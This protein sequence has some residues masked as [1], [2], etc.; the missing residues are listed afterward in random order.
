MDYCNIEKIINVNNN[1]DWLNP[2]NPIDIVNDYLSKGWILLSIDCNSNADNTSHIRQY[3][4]G[5][6][7]SNST[8]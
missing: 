7:K 8:E 4:L 6:P 2:N 3:I 1:T 5:Y